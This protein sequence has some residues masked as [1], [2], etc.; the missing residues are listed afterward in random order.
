MAETDNWTATYRDYRRNT[1][2][3]TSEI[4]RLTIQM[5]AASQAISSAE[6]MTAEILGAAR[7][8]SA[9]ATRAHAA[10]DNGEQ[11]ASDAAARA[12]IGATKGAQDSMESLMGELDKAAT[13]AKVAASG[14]NNLLR[15]SPWTVAIYV[16]FT[17]VIAA[18]SGTLAYYIEH[19]RSVQ[20]ENDQLHQQSLMLMVW[21]NAK[22]AEIKVMEEILRRSSAKVNR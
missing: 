18:L 2:R 21:Q 8:L 11:V 20:F 13:A 19:E 10:W 5:E 4:D 15:R 22:P 1:E 16:V 3:L 14:M 7:K 12:V 17:L 6:K 9:E